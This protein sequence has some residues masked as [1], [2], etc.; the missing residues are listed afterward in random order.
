[1]RTSLTLAAPPDATP[2]AVAD[3]RG[4]LRMRTTALDTQLG[5]AV[6]FAISRV[7]G[8]TGL[9]NRALITQSW[10]AT[11]DRFPAEI[12]VPLARCQSVEALKY[13][14]AAGDEQ[15]LAPSSYRLTG[16]N[17]DLTCIQPVTGLSW[18]T[19]ATDRE[20][21]RLEFT[22]GFGDAADDVP[23]SIRYALL[24]IAADAFGN[25]ESTGPADALA[26]VPYAARGALQDWIVWPIDG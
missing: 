18:P 12:A 26:A 20:A 11:Y 1:M 21:V 9:L 10:R 16:L 5:E 15:T 17:S 23:A 4:H 6:D 24:Q 25:P 8:P 19:I 22:S 7:D 3:L 13:L 2:I 14:D